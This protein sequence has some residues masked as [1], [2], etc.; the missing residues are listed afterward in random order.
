MCHS[1]TTVGA[2]DTAP[3]GVAVAAATNSNK[4]TLTKLCFAMLIE[5]LPAG[6]A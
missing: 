1:A 3:M 5:S 2:A 6:S 4:E